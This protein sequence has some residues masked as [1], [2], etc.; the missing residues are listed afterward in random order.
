MQTHYF[1]TKILLLPESQLRHS[2]T[3]LVQVLHLRSQIPHYLLP[4]SNAPY[5]HSHFP[6]LSSL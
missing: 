3:K 5:I 2:F 4:N 6:L 1:P